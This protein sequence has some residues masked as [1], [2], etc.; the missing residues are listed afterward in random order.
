MYDYHAVEEGDGKAVFVCGQFGD[1]FQRVDDVV[2]IRTSS[3]V[4]DLVSD[5]VSGDRVVKWCFL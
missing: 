4:I 2:D 5:D 1:L 3:D